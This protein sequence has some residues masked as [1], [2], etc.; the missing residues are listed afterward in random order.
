MVRPARRG[1]LARAPGAPRTTFYPRR[2]RAADRPVRRLQRPL[3]SPATPAARVRPGARPR[4]PVP[5]VARP[6]RALRLH[7]PN[8][9]PSPVGGLPRRPRPPPRAP[10]P[11]TPLPFFSPPAHPVAVF[12]PAPRP[13]RR[14]PWR[15]RTPSRPSSARPCG[16]CTPLGTM[17]WRCCPHWGRLLLRPPLP[18]PPPRPRT[19]ALPPPPPAHAL[20]LPP[21]RERVHAGRMARRRRGHQCHLRHPPRDAR[22]QVGCGRSG[23]GGAPQGRPVSVRRGRRRA[24]W[25]FHQ[26]DRRRHAPWGHPQRP[27]AGR[28]PPL[29]GRLCV[30][31]LRGHGR[32]GRRVRGGA[33]GGDG[34]RGAARGGPRVDRPRRRGGLPHR[35][36]HEHA[37]DAARGA[38]VGAGTDA[39]R[40]AGHRLGGRPRRLDAAVGAPRPDRPTGTGGGVGRRRRR[41]R[42]RR[43]WRR[44]AARPVGAPDRRA[45]R[46]GGVPAPPA[47]A[48]PAPRHWGRRRRR[49]W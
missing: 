26:L 47:G 3:P 40:R 25:V 4:S 10:R 41:G 35:R 34:R 45:V 9:P 12:F 22:P 8:G 15:A 20:G 23:A 39:R 32:P 38:A 36:R 13:A 44:R 5:P 48:L 46:G 14:Q 43:W 33:G 42:R 37:G 29:P 28:R 7:P 16:T 21:R 49:R 1:R 11:P 18:R 27:G 2:R 31:W 17:P 24:H 19:W 6:W 30:G